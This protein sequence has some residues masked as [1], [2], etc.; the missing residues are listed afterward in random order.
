[1]RLGCHTIGLAIENPKRQR[2]DLSGPLPSTAANSVPTELMRDLPATSPRPSSSVLV[3]SYALALAFTALFSLFARPA[4]LYQFAPASPVRAR[5]APASMPSA[6]P[7]GSRSKLGRMR[8]GGTATEGV[9]AWTAA[10][11]AISAATS[12]PAAQE[13]RPRRK[14]DGVRTHISRRRIMTVLSVDGGSRVQSWRRSGETIRPSVR[15]CKGRTTNAVAGG[16]PRCI[17]AMVGRHGPIAGRDAPGPLSAR[18]LRS[19]R[20]GIR[21]PRAPRHSRA[22]EPGPSRADRRRGTGLA[23]ADRSFPDRHLRVDPRRPV[24]LPAPARATARQALRG[25]P[26]KRH[27]A[28]ARQVRCGHDRRQRSPTGDAGSQ[29]RGAHLR[30]PRF[31]GDRSRDRHAAREDRHRSHRH[32]SRR[33][34]GRRAGPRGQEVHRSGGAADDPGRDSASR[35]PSGPGPF[36]PRPAGRGGGNPARH[37]PGSPQPLGGAGDRGGRQAVG[38]DP[39]RGRQG[40]RRGGGAGRG[41]EEEAAEG[42]PAVNPRRAMAATAALVLLAALGAG[43]SRSASQDQRRGWSGEIA[44]LEAEQDSLRRRVTELIARDPKIQALP[45]GDI[46]AAVPTAFLRDV[47]EH[48]F[49]DVADHVTLSLSG[50]RAHV[51]KTVKK[52]VTIGEFVVDV[53]SLKAVGRL[54][55]GK[56]A[57]TFGRGGVSLTLPVTVTEGRGEAVINFVWNGKNVAGVTCGDMDIRQRVD[58]TLV[59]AD[60]VLSGTLGFDLRGSRAVG[61]FHFPETRLQ[62]RVKPS[63][64]SWDAINALLE[65][66]RGVCGWVLDKVDVP[67]LL[68]GVVETKGFNVKIPLDRLQP[69]RFPAGAQDSVTVGGRTLAVSAQTRTFRIDPDAIWYS[70]DVRVGSTVR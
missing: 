50:L 7:I 53:D 5:Y 70:A 41:G 58:G 2:W 19:V 11:V 16:H 35:G 30:R 44:R 55:P 63:Q 36:D 4:G 21:L 24:P 27:R 49:E 62:I 31:G 32:P 66:K 46:V 14:G 12:R 45:E 56:P 17:A 65:E 54:R 39:G 26:R 51:A 34:P 57:L 15:P 52:V 28:A 37:A 67:S 64:K 48:L 60:Y 42:S 23:G 18:G 25:A 68:S 61:T 38:H 59:P 33:N 69:L 8:L 1:M 29:D 3:H 9:C 43:C 40:D 10:G 6:W 22:P 13:K 20:A 47:I